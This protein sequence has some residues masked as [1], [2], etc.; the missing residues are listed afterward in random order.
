MVAA[1]AANAPTL[2]AAAR[3]LASPGLSR[4]L[5]VARQAVASEGFRA[6]TVNAR[7]FSQ[8]ISQQI[9]ELQ[10]PD[11]EVRV[12]TLAADTVADPDAALEWASDDVVGVPDGWEAI[13]AIAST[14]SPA[15]KRELVLRIASLLAAA[16]VYAKVM[17]G[18]EPGTS[19]AAAGAML[20]LAWLYHTVLASIEDVENTLRDDTAD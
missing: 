13:P 16:V 9:L 2:Q 15:R 1:S 17:V 10:I 6:A 4:S 5:E 3:A 14:L 12:K 7:R 8:Q 20:A 19:D 11:I 18:I